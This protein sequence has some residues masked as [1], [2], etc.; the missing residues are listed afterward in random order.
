MLGVFPGV[1]GGF[2]SWFSNLFQNILVFPAVSLALLLGQLLTKQTGPRWTPPVMGTSGEG[3]TGLLAMGVL[4]I[5]GSIPDAIKTVFAGKPFAYGTAIGE[6]LGPA[7][8]AATA[9][10]KGGGAAWLDKLTEENQWPVVQYGL[11]AIGIK[12]TARPPSGPTPGPGQVPS[13]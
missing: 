9:G 5:V 11:R 3:L 10:Y 6:A 4:L 13:A 8:F 2:G 12:G 7:K 1:K